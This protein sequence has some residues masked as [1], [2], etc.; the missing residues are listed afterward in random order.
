MF[1]KAATCLPNIDTLHI[2]AS[3]V[4]ATDMRQDRD[5]A[6]TVA[7]LKGMPVLVDMLRRCNP[8]ELRRVHVLVDFYVA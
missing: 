4:L 3:D 2:Y 5:E 6:T 8:K 7:E 1:I